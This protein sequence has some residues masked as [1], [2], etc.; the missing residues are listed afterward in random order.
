ME[1]ASSY[2]AD[3]APSGMM[4]AKW[5]TSGMVNVKSNTSGMINGNGTLVE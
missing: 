2:E 5:N 4:N 3:I 1:K